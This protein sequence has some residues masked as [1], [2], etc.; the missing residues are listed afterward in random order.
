MC[1]T[2]KDIVAYHVPREMITK[3]PSAQFEAANAPRNK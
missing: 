3:V 2:E 1:N